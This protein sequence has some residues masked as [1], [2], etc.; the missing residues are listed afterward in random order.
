TSMDD[1]ERIIKTIREYDKIQ[2]LFFIDNSSKKN[3]YL[4]KILK[5]NIKYI[6]TEKNLGYGKGHNIAMKESM[7]MNV[8]FHLV[9]NPDIYFEI[10]T[11]EKLSA[12]MT[13]QPKIGH[14]MPK[15]VY[16]DKSIQY[17]CKLLPSP[18]NLFARSFLPRKLYQKLNEKYELRISGY[19]K[20]INVPYL[21]GCFMF[22]R[23]T[24]LKEVGIFDERFFMYP[25]DIDLTRRIHKK[26]KT[27]FYPDVSVIHRHEKA[28]FKSLKM[29]L[30]HIVN[31]IKYFNKYY[32]FLD[33]ERL[34]INQK[35]L[36]QFK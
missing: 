26:Y 29:K 27:V 16:P 25:E 14:L 13:N 31:M 35:I 21:S 12:F 17:L 7:K 24:C 9:L 28:S 34:K 3:E 10:E 32:W 4:E 15:V 8:D 36:N 23:V 22:L 18:F 30:I 33:L 6:F 19:N 11:L 1:I 20:V 2:T 5:K